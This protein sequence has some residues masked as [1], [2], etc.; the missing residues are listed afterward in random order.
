MNKKVFP[1]ISIIFII[2]YFVYIIA[3]FKTHG[4]GIAYYATG[5]YPLLALLS[6]L[7]AAFKKNWLI[8]PIIL[9]SCVLLVV[10][11]NDVSDVVSFFP[12]L[13]MYIIYSLFSGLCFEK[14]RRD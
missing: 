11:G 10:A 5:I 9:H 1:A 3:T 6:G 13:V 12:R 4:Q 14:L 2:Y 8:V 7:P